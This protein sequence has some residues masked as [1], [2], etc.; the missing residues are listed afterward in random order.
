MRRCNEDIDEIRSS[1][2]ELRRNARSKQ[3][4]INRR[5][6]EI[7]VLI[8]RSHGKIPENRVPFT[9]TADC[10]ACGTCVPECPVN[11]I[12]DGDIYEID[13]ETC[14]ACKKCADVCPVHA[15]IPM[16]GPS[17]S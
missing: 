9:I 2:F 8:L 16:T 4:E 15:C 1:L 13:P 3:A 12:A 6:A 5:L 17:K 14:I 11:A 7:R 10:I